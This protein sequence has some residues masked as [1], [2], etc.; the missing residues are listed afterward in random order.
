MQLNI[1]HGVSLF[2]QLKNFMQLYL[3]QSIQ[4]IRSSLIGAIV[5]SHVD[6][7]SRRH[8]Q[9]ISSRNCD[10]EQKEKALCS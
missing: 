10:A 9:D 8:L 5:E 7:T 2:S 4:Y 3:L 1:L 6:V